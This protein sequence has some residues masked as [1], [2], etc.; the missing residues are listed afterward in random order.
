MAMR[1][2]QGKTTAKVSHVSISEA[3]SSSIGKLHIKLKN[4]HEFNEY[5]Q[6]EAFIKT[7]FDTTKLKTTTHTY[8]TTSHKCES[9]HICPWQF[10]RVQKSQA[11]GLQAALAEHSARLQRGHSLSHLLTSEKL[12]PQVHRDT[13]THLFGLSGSGLTL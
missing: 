10:P 7:A 12:P 11:H 13:G 1:K 2:R 5:K 3:L 8:N 9:V 4:G 6:K